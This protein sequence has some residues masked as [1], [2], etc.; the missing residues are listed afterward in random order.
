MPG[1]TEDEILDLLDGEKCILDQL[2]DPAEDRVRSSVCPE[3]GT[4][5]QPVVDPLS[6]FERD[7]PS[8][9]FIGQCPDCG[10]VFDPDTGPIRKPS[11]GPILTAGS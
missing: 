2:S 6:P 9:K 8:F 4:R 10:C 7:L 3:C 11:T 5:A 1:L